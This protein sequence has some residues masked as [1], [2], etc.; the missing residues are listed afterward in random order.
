[1]GRPYQQIAFLK[2]KN[3]ICFDGPLAEQIHISHF[4][5]FRQIVQPETSGFRTCPSGSHFAALGHRLDHALDVVIS[6]R[7]FLSPAGAEHTVCD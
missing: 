6:L 1:M 4:H 3:M 7:R 5:T 2:Y